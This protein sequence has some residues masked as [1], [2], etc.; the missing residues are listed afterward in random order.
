MKSLQTATL[1]SPIGALSLWADGDALVGLEFTDADARV[2]GLKAHLAKRL[3]PFE[4][5]PCDDPAG[6]ATRLRRYF[7]GDL[8]ALEDQRVL[9]LGT[10]FEKMV[11]ATLRGIPVGEVRSYRQVARAIGEPKATRAVG[12]ANG[13]NPVAIVVPCHRVI[14][15]DGSLHGYGG[16]LERKKWL[17]EHEKALGP[18]RQLVIPGT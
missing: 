6:A 5:L 1:S 15:A 13:H 9:M 14:A 8:H 2:S 10:E 12:S 16:G 7:E 11:W 3:G 18:D 4:A 17:L